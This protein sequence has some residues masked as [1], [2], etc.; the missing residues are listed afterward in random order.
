MKTTVLMLVAAAPLLVACGAGSV[1][2]SEV[3]SD[4]KDKLGAEKV[5]CPD[6]LEAVEGET[7]TCDATIDGEERTLKLTVT[8]VEDNEAVWTVDFDE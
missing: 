7:M 3:E 6:D 1:A 8:K 4:T 5:D 2:E